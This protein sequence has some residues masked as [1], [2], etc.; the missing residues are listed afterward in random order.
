KVRSRGASARGLQG[1]ED[2]VTPFSR[3]ARRRSPLSARSTKK[4]RHLPGFFCVATPCRA[5]LWGCSLLLGG[6]R[7]V[8]Y[9]GFPGLVG[10]LDENFG[11][12]FRLGADDHL[13][14]RVF[15]VNPLHVGAY[16]AYIDAAS[17]QH[18]V[19]TLADLEH[20]VLVFLVGW[21]LVR[22]WRTVDVN[23]G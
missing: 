22:G 3:G 8:V 11:L 2:Q 23:A 19:A 5:H 10:D 17:L 18:D 4:A 12:G 7:D 15:G 13:G 14:L 9:A 1:S 16:G 21:R 20:D 6:A